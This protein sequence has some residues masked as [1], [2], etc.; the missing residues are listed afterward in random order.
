MTRTPL[1]LLATAGSAALL[2]GALGFQYLGGL[3]PC[4]LC[5]WQRWPHLA[6]VLIGLLALRIREPLLPLAGALAALTTAA[7]GGFHTGVELGWWEGLQSCQGAGIATLSLND[8][9]DPTANAPDPVRCDQV[10]WS[11]LGLSMAAWNMIA[12]LGLTV[13][14]LLAAKKSR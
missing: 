3:F 12:S 6:A 11:F 4:P 1:I 14:W 10:A 5:I 13:L 9:L 8:L 7:I 2:L